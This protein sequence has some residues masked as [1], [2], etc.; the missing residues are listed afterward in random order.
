MHIITHIAAGYWVA[1]KSCYCFLGH[2]W[3]KAN[4][5]YYGFICTNLSN[6]S[7]FIEI[8]FKKVMLFQQCSSY[9]VEKVIYFSKLIVMLL[10][11]DG[12]LGQACTSVH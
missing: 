10:L 2:I 7:L 5:F 9:Q 4:S 6:I 3:W 12:A 11:H 1:I 8:V